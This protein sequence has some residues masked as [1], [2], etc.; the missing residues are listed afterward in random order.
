M[1]LRKYG[2]R[3]RVDKITS[4]GKSALCSIA[5]VCR[6][7]FRALRTGEELVAL[8]H[9]AL[10][11]LYR[12]GLTPLVSSLPRQPKASFSTLDK[13]DPFGLGCALGGVRTRSEQTSEMVDAPF[14]AKQ[15]G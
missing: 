10:A 4:D 13:N 15:V 12:V 14:V 3:L 1:L 5:H 6:P 8:A 2:V 7:W 11:P 9:A